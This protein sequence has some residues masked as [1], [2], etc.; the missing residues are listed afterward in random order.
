[1]P[2]FLLGGWVCHAQRVARRR[3]A[4][5][6]RMHGFGLYLRTVY[7]KPVHRSSWRNRPKSPG[8][9][10]SG[11]K[12]AAS[13]LGGRLLTVRDWRPECIEA[14]APTEREATNA[15]FAL[16]LA[17]DVAPRL[18]GVL[19]LSYPASVSALKYASLRH[20]LV[21]C[22][23]VRSEG[24]CPYAGRT[25]RAPTSRTNFGTR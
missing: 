21:S 9:A 14:C 8:G 16:A 12:G 1:M 19:V 2:G 4:R 25:R 18:S 17:V 23:G 11:K 20:D 22:C 7:T 5:I 6:V 10:C 13:L 3:A 24:S 15:G